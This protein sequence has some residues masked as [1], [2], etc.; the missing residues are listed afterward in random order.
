MAWR[1][2]RSGSVIRGR[3]SGVGVCGSGGSGGPGGQPRSRGPTGPQTSSFKYLFPLSYIA[4]KLKSFPV[5]RKF[6]STSFISIA[7]KRYQFEFRSSSHHR[8]FSSQNLSSCQ[9]GKRDIRE[10]P[11]YIFDPITIFFQL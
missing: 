8:Q 5:W 6:K 10:I 1:L 7:K 9:S 4:N 2:T 3:W 11:D